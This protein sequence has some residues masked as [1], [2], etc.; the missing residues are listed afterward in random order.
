MNKELQQYATSYENEVLAYEQM[1]RPEFIQQYIDQNYD[2]ESS[3]EE[4]M[5]Q[6]YFDPLEIQHYR[7]ESSEQDYFEITLGF[8]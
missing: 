1:E 3:D 5:I 8:G 7:N 4:A 6:E 2:G